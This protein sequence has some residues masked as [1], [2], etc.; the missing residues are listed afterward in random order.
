MATRDGEGDTMKISRVAAGVAASM[1][2]AALVLAPGV[3]LAASSTASPAASAANSST[4]IYAGSQEPTSLNPL[5]GYTG[6]DYTIWAIEYNLPIE[7]GLNFEADMKNSITTSVD[8]SSDNMSFTYHIRPGMKWSDGEPFTA[9][10]VAW[11][12]NYYKTNNVSNYSSD[13]TLMTKA[14]VIND[15]TFVIHTSKP[16]TVY[17]GDTPVMYEYILPEHIWSKF[18]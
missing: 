11:T 13:L 16:T 5:K 14:D 1:I 15:T 9:N 3:S 10:D 12:L 2:L 6:T 17:S 4:F 18:K 8:T 7:F